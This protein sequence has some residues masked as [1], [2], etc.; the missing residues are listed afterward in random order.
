M[1]LCLSCSLTAYLHRCE[2]KTRVRQANKHTDTFGLPIGS[3]WQLLAA[4]GQLHA[5][6]GY[7]QLLAA[8]GQFHA[9]AGY[10]QPLKAGMQTV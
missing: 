8:A 9:I 5:I 4:A 2:Q 3:Y 10:W 7:W 1:T 6:A